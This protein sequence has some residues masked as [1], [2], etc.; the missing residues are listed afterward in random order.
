MKIHEFI[1]NLRASLRD[2][3]SLCVCMH[4][5]EG[6]RESE[7]DK[8]NVHRPPSFVYSRSQKK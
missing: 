8:L 5:K 4:V 2:L 7:L 6:A 3:E 1:V